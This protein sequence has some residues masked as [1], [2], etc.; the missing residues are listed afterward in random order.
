MDKIRS[1]KDFQTMVDR[2][3]SDPQYRNQIQRGLQKESGKVLE[4]EL[5]KIS[6]PKEARQPAAQPQA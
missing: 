2:Y 4:T 5:N 6:H 3:V 1:N